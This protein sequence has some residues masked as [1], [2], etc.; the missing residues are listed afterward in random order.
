MPLAIWLHIREDDSVQLEA[1]ITKDGLSMT[2][3][4][5][6]AYPRQASFSDL[7]LLMA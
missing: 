2:R 7:Y 4:R 5:P 6:S 1:P 3:L